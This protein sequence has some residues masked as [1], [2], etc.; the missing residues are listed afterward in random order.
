MTSNQ[1]QREKEK[2]KFLPEAR[3]SCHKKGGY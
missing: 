3:L 2:E 1:R